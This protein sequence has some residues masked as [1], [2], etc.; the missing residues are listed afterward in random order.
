[1]RIFIEP[2]DVLLF[3]DGRP[4]SAGDDH[5]A[6]S[7]FPPNPMTFQGALRSLILSQ[8]SFDFRRASEFIGVG[9]KDYG[10]LQMKGPFLARKDGD[11]TEYFPVP[12]DVVVPKSRLDR[13]QDRSMVLSPVQP[14]WRSDLNQTLLSLWP[15]SS[16]HLEPASGFVSQQ[17]LACYLLG[18]APQLIDQT[19][20]AK[21]E[22]RT[23]IKRQLHTHAATRGRLY[24]VAFTRLERGVGFTL[25][26]DGLPLQPR[27]LLM[28]GG[29]ARAAS[30]QSVPD[31]IWPDIITNIKAKISGS[32]PLRFK[33]Y[34]AT[35]AIF[36]QGWLPADFD[37][38]TLEG[39]L[40]G[41]K[42]RLIAAAVGRPLPIGGWDL[43]LK[44]PKP[45]K[46]AVPAGS[47]YYFEAISSS[48]TVDDIF[49]KLHF[50]CISDEHSQ[51]GFGLTFVGG[52]NQC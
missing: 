15:R 28:L 1:M 31:R 33:L 38:Q 7:V 12:S 48:I 27:G 19:E 6:R 2:I 16:A 45:I 20:F 51:I 46:K 39:T 4:F 32:Q 9:S 35:P 30:Y 47:V 36:T 10:K 26:V 50:Q 34:F 13:V 43:R 24:A 21:A 17:D 49:D 44:Q 42:L 23:A 14:R 8:H 3:R 41:V 25:D 37:S 11:I 52:C 22:T 18:D 40:K 29:E 5:T